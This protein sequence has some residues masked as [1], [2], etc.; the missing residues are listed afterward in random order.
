[1][2]V[3][4]LLGVALAALAL[5]LPSTPSLAASPGY[6]LTVAGHQV[7]RWNPC[8][9]IHWRVNL[10]HAPRGSFADVKAAISRLHKAT[11]IRFVL[12]GQ[13]NAIPQTTFGE[14]SLPGHYPPLTIA[15]AAPGHGKGDSDALKKQDAGVGGIYYDQWFSTDGDLNPTQV[16]TGLVVM[17]DLYNG[18]YRPGFGAGQTRG[19]V[20]LHELGHAVGLQHVADPAQIMYPVAIARPK[21]EYGKGDLAG[22]RRV[23][24]KAG[25]I[26]PIKP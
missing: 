18:F 9:A 11:G 15:W 17:N 21:A 14:D 3:L 1:M 12:D 16:V 7:I 23:G 19:E 5:L 6:A 13:T 4:R 24:R 2:R 8:A 25:C 22:L 26:R 20:L 10:A